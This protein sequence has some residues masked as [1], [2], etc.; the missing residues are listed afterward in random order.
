MDFLRNLPTQ[1]PQQLAQ[2]IQIQPGRV[3][4]MAMSRQAHCQMTLLAF[5]AGES[6]SEEHYFGDNIKM[7]S[8]EASWLLWSTFFYSRPVSNLVT[9][10]S[11]SSVGSC[12]TNNT[13]FPMH[14]RR[15]SSMTNCLVSRSSPLN[16]SSRISR[17]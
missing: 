3:V 12:V 4:S 11:S 16:G 13:V 10:R 14:R 6:I 2:L 1:H 8:I 15:V 5:G 17:S 9:P 7:C